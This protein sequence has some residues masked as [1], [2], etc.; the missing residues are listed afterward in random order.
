MTAA[1]F[2]SQMVKHLIIK[3]WQIYQKQLAAYVVG[4]LVG[5]TLVGVGKA[6]AFYVGG[7]LLLVLL[8]CAGV[9]AIQS[10]LLNERKEH[11]LSFVMSLP[12]TPMGFYWSKLLANVTIYLVPF[13]L[14][15]GGSAFLILFTPLPDGLLVW[16]LLIYGFLAMIFF[17]SLC[18]ALVLEAEGWN[19]FVQLGLSTMISPFMMGIGMVEP[20]GTHIKTNNIVWSLPAI[21]ILLAQVAVAALAIGLT[22]WLQRR[23]TSFL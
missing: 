21:G 15:V 16:S 8:I 22:S 4:L 5:L 23:K 10:S 19:I 3:D 9:F 20:I 17:V 13:T 12:V 6:W 11:T 14:V 18:A 2:D 7:L 1:S